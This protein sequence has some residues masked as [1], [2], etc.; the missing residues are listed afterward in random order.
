MREIEQKNHEFSQDYAEVQV[1]AADLDWNSS[2]L[3]NALRM[4]LSK[5]MNI[6]FM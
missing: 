3:W 5:E 4:G 6:N 1:I 2:A